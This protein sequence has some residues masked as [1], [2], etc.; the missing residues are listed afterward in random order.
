MARRTKAPSSVEVQRVPLSAEQQS[1]IDRACAEIDEDRMRK[2]NLDI[3]AI[4]SPTGYERQVNE[5]IVEHLRKNGIEAFYQPMDEL[6]GNAVGRLR[7]SGGGPS[8]LLYAPIDTHLNADPKEDIPWAARELRPDMLPNAY[9]DQN[10]N[11]IGL[12]ASNPKGMVTALT[13]ATEAIRRAAIPLRGDIV[14]AFAGGGMP[15]FQAPDYPGMNHGLGSG[16]NY[17][18]THGVTADFGII[19]KP[20]WG[21]FWEEVGLCWFKV[22]VRGTMNYAGMPRGI[23]GWRSSPVAAAK[24]LLALEE[25]LP[26]YTKMVT[27]GQVAPEGNISAVRGGWPYKVAFPPATTEIYLDIRCSPRVPPAEV[28]AIFATAIEGIRA[29]LPDVEMD[30]EMIAAYPGASTDPNNWIIQSSM[31]GWEFVEGRP[32]EFPP[33]VSGQTDASMIRN[34]G[35]PLARFGQ[36]FPSPQAP[37]EWD[38]LGGMGVSSMP[39]LVKV[40]K[41][42]VYAAIDTC[43][44]TRREVGLAH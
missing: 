18:L 19:S 32:N 34:L 39:D 3:T 16:V 21:V 38:G 29:K 43:S 6:S 17:M 9:I 4:H 40:A 12:G 1:W 10:N 24:V 42:A 26:K 20:W 23:P 33:P 8:L 30:W 14:L 15:T 37:P 44:R 2:F 28:R 35:I 11:V 27:S 5:F 25:W 31:R 36:P 22:S 13:A 7:G 41:A